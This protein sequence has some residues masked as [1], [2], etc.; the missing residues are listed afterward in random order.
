MLLALALTGCV[1]KG[2]PTMTL[3][4]AKTKTIALQ[5][6]V[7]SFVPED[8]ILTSTT[9]ETST[10]IFPCDAGGYYW[11]GQTTMTLKEGL[12]ANSVLSEIIGAWEKKPGWSAKDQTINGDQ[13]RLDLLEEDGT[14][15]FVTFREGGLVFDLASFSPCFDLGSEPEY[16]RRY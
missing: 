15:L 11:P 16:G 1:M 3:E 5:A 13:R 12:D 8:F 6:E 7:S 2:N 10:V 4:E 14:H 9:A